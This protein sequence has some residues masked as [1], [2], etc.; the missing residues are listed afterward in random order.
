MSHSRRKFIRWKKQERRSR[1]KR[2]I[3]PGVVVWVVH[4]DWLDT[5]ARSPDIEV[6]VAGTVIRRT[7]YGYRHDVDVCL[8]FP[9]RC[10]VKTFP[11]Y[12]VS[13]HRPVGFGTA[14]APAFRHVIRG[15]YDN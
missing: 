7:Q 11:I 2:W 12:Q 10:Q 6:L 4:R 14:R 5:N 15:S 9:G 8:H 13:T 1:E 3:Q